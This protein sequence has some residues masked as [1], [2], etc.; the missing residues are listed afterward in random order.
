MVFVYGGPGENMVTNKFEIGWQQFMVTN[1][2][3]AVISIDGRG[4]AFGSN[5]QEPVGTSVVENYLLQ[6]RKL[7]KF[8][9]SLNALKRFAVNKKLGKYEIIDQLQ[10]VDAACNDPDLVN[11]LDCSRMAIMGWR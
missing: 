9:L 8:F 2:S 3:I 10:G 7:C 6:I 4:S 1:R 5:H 11:I